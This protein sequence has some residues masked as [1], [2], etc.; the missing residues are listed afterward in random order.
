MNKNKEIWMS[1]FALFSL[2]FGAG[3]LI[4]PPFLGANSGDQWVW[5]VFGFVI[6]AVI[7]PILGILAHAKVQGTLY[8]LGKKV[9]PW[10]SSLFCFLIYLIAITLP[11][12]RTAS[13][14]HEMAIQPFFGTSSLLTSSIYFLLTFIFVVN[15]SKILSLIGKFLTPIIVLILL[16]IISL[17]LFSSSGMMVENTYEVPFVSGILEGYQ[18]FDAIGGVVVGAV[19]IISL[20]LRGHTSYSAKKELITKSGLIAGGGLLLIYGGLISSGAILSSTFGENA[21]RTEILTSLS[22]QTLGNIGTSFLSVLVALACFTT[23]VGIITGAADYVKGLFKDS[24]QAY[25][26]TA[27]LS[28]VLGVLIGQFDVHYIINVAIPALMFIYPITII[29]ILL[30]VMPNKL[31]NPIVFKGVVIITFLFSIPDF[32]G[33]LKLGGILEPVVKWIP[34]SSQSLGWVLPA[35]MTFVLLNL[36]NVINKT[37][38]ID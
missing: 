3:N 22:T 31:A 38:Q 1:G 17:A 13:V 10:F 12:P 37:Q 28:C 2:F 14:T 11:A 29:L 36:K 32:L 5:V 8:D 33:S 27:F 16:T 19:I 9:S 6:T 4:L 15:R 21:T 23:G 18:T 35:L 24:Q 7:I 30:N 34:L 20:N 25:F 26:I